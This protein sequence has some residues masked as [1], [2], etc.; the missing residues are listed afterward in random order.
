MK[1]FT[2]L[3]FIIISFNIGAFEYAGIK[4]GM[5]KSE[6]L[7]IPGWGSKNK[8][9]VYKKDVNYD[10]MFG[11]KRPAHLKAI[12]TTFTPESGR[13]YKMSIIV[14]IGNRFGTDDVIQIEALRQTLIKVELMH[15]GDGKVEQTTEEQYTSNG[16]VNVPILGAVLFDEDIYNE[17]LKA[18]ESKFSP[19]Y[20][21]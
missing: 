21:K 14:S 9:D 19:Q 6:I 3:F 18:L 16:Y 1:I 5:T 12:R 13:L 11:G 7:Q 20:L 2:T 17:E 10:V 15:G 8:K 4:S